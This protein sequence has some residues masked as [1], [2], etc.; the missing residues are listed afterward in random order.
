MRRPSA[1]CRRAVQSLQLPTAHHIWIS[2]DLLARALNPFFPSSCPHQRRHGSNVPGPL[3]A[4]RRA[5]KR[6]MTVS[7]GFHPQYT[8][9]SLFNL[10]ALFAFRRESEPTWRYEAP[11]LQ[12]RTEPLDLLNQQLPSSQ[13]P[14][15]DRISHSHAVSAPQ[16]NPLAFP[17]PD[18]SE[19]VSTGTSNGDLEQISAHALTR[20]DDFKSQVIYAGDLSFAE[21]NRL[22]ANAWKSCCPAHS[23]AWI[24]NIMVV[25]HVEKLG[26][27]P[28]RILLE[29]ESFALPPMYT[30]QSQNFL[31]CLRKSSAHFPYA[32]KVYHDVSMRVVELAGSATVSKNSSQDTEL[33]SIIRLA[34]Q[35]A[36][37]TDN[38]IEPSIA[39]AL[40][41]VA[42]K[43]QNI[44]IR[45]ALLS[46]LTGTNSVQQSTIILLARA[47]TDH[48]LC[49]TLEKTL[50]CLPRKQLRSL[51]PSVT[52]SLA[53][54]VARE[55]RLPHRVHGHPLRAW[56]KVLERLDRRSASHA[57][58][59]DYLGTAFAAVNKYVFRNSNASSMRGLVLLHA[60][61]FQL[62]Q[63]TL[64]AS[65]RER[66]LQLI[67]AP[68]H[69]PQ[70][71]PE[72]ETLLGLVFARMQKEGLPCTPLV[73]LTVYTFTRHADLMSVYRILSTLK[74]QG[75]VLENA[76]SIQSRFIK[77]AASLPRKTESMN[78]Q[79]RQHYAF[80][81]RTCQSIADLLI[82]LVP[83]SS[84]STASALS[85][86][87]KHLLHLQAR[88]EFTAILERAS[89]NHAL[90]QIYATTTADM[91]TS[92]RTVLIHQLAHFYSL[93]TTR[94][95]RETWRSIYYL[96]S[97][98]QT[99][100]L[101][102]GPLFTKAVVRA[103]IIRPMMEHRFISARRL[104]W[105]CHLVARV[106]GE[107][108]AKQIE[109]SYWRWRGELIR[110][111]KR[112][113]DDAGGDVKA[114][115][116]VGKMKGLGL[117]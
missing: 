78:E 51:I 15:F 26:W 54:A 55:T 34:L 52:I 80:A 3:E 95:H 16:P 61:T 46:I 93:S 1:A 91:P 86:T 68:V 94:S 87:K 10:G 13:V 83:P 92:D 21:R 56:F 57:S 65:Y 31:D 88:R 82:K 70:E 27:D 17:N 35:G 23:D 48:K 58:S 33:L 103:A 97:Y 41:L 107:D 115:A 105:V 5:A 39:Q 90:P 99:Y 69:T 67:Y 75:F 98:L 110:H 40:A 76:S 66:V 14:Q 43:I 117:V 106:E 2:D 77:R 18:E 44:D 36:F 4:R 102:I 111:A 114:K 38:K 20:F 79:A 89:A 104:I 32:A 59:A 63:Q 11:S 74:Q 62:T 81:L 30:S 116:M 72:F 112:A 84:K 24:Y 42:N 108:V 109:S 64:Y 45:E 53:I 28:S 50:S 12:H 6:R 8:F 101:P 25:E 113:H 96:Y 60:L 37:P 29:H 85:H 19:C 47:A 73:D 9:Q 71:R 22:L 49:A 7:A 100:S